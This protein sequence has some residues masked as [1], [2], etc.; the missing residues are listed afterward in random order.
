MCLIFGKGS[1]GLPLL[2][3]ESCTLFSIVRIYS[4]QVFQ[5]N[6]FLLRSIVFL[7]FSLTQLFNT[8]LERSVLSSKRLPHQGGLVEREQG[9]E[10]K[11]YQLFTN[12]SITVFLASA[13]FLR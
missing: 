5:A 12:K 13:N 3:K 4:S 2:Q 8:K 6:K 7:T 1:L 11:S 10:T 9:L